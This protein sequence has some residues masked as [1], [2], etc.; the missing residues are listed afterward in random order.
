MK[1]VAIIPARYASTRL[2]GKPLLAETGMPL[3]GHV[4]EAAARADRLDA[5]YVATDDERIREAVEAFGGRAVMTRAD[6]ASGTDRLAEA[7]EALGLADD[8]IVVNVQ[9]DEPEIDPG[10]I[11]RLVGLLVESGAPMATLAAPLDAE[12]AA[13]PN[14]VKVVLAADGTALYFS[15]ARIPYDRD[16]AGA[17]YLLHMGIYAYRKRFLAAFAALAPTP[18]ERTERLEQLRALENGHRIA[19]GV[20]PAAAPGIDTPDDYAAFVRRH[21][22]G[23]SQQRKA[24]A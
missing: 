16:G 17:D 18:L 21:A 22:A 6:H 23:G 3:I 24:Q 14:H 4:V 9:G 2:P 5:V 20:V 7:A 1:A 19:V 11:D 10:Y 13:S 15:R 12:A 8:D